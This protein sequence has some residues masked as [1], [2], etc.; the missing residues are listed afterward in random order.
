MGFSPQTNRWQCGPFALKHALIMLGILADESAIS[1]LSGANRL[2]GTNEFQLAR[3]ARKFDCDLLLERSEDSGEARRDLVEHLRLGLP[4]LVCINEW[5]HWVT[6]VKEEKGRFIV[7]DSRDVAVLVILTWKQLE[8]RW[9]YHQEEKGEAKTLYD[10]HPVIPLFRTQT[11]AR[12]SLARARFLRRPE[13]RDFAR[14][15]DKYVED[16]LAICRARTPLSSNILS[17]GE[18]LRR[19]GE[20]VLDQ[21]AFWHGWIERRRAA[22]V[23]AN[24]HFVADTYGLVIHEEDEKRALAGITSLLT[25]WAGGRYGVTPVYPESPR[26]SRAKN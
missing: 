25:L 23:L 6:I 9:V 26:K 5:S 8:S 22:K 12:V 10:F 4:C 17:L 15:W 16:L 21:V 19:Y 7:L 2:S 20:M 13:N 14:Q 1:K 11:R 3:A 18:F 24:L